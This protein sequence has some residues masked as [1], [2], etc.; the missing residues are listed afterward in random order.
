MKRLLFLTVITL[1]M[2]LLA[3]GQAKKEMSVK[4][5]FLAIP[6][7]FIKAD[8]KKRVDWIETEENSIGFLSFKMPADEFPGGEDLKE[9]GVVYGNVQVFKK[10]GGG[11]VIGLAVNLCAEGKCVGQMLLLDYNAGKWEDLTSDLSPMIDNDEVVKILKNA[12][13]Y[14]NKDNLKDGVEVPLAIEFNGNGKAINYLAGC[15][16]GCDGAV[17]AKTFKWN[18]SIFKEFEEAESPE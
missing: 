7:E 3:F 8:A 4:E 2:N 9:E 13:A 16:G 17:V 18:G 5:Y 10:T 12:P 1:I 11:A 14:E 15:V 6:N